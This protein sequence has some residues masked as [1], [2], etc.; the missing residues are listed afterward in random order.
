MSSYRSLSE[1]ISERFDFSCLRVEQQ[2]GERNN[3]AYSP[4]QILIANET[5]ESYGSGR[6]PSPE[7]DWKSTYLNNNQ[8]EQLKGRVRASERDRERECTGTECRVIGK[9]ESRAASTA[10]CAA[11]LDLK[12]I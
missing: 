10:D 5:S 7:P 4:R 8:I 11:S 9:L 12:L 2:L 3:S 6:N 1:E